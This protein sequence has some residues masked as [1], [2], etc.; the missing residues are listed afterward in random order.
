MKTRKAIIWLSLGHFVNDTYTG[1]I[2]PVMPFIAAKLGITMAAAALVLSISNIFSSMLQPIFGFFADNMLKRLFIFWGLIFTS[3]FIPLMTAA[4]NVYVLIIFIILGSLG[5]S[6]YHPQSTGFVNKFAGAENARE[7]GFFMSMGSAGYA[8]GPLVAAVVTQYFT[9]EK[10]PV[11]SILG[12]LLAG[13]MFLCVPRLSQIYPNPEYK[14]FK[15][16]FAAILSNKTM[17]LLMTVSMMKVLISTSCCTL[18]PFL[19]KNE[20]GYSPLYIGTAL[21]LFVIAGAIGSITSRN[22]EIILGTKN[23]LYF[24]MCATLPMIIT[25]HFTY[26]NHPI[27]SLVMFIITGYTTMLGQPVTM[28][29]G[30]KLLPQ[31]KSTVAGFMNGFAVGVVAVFLSL[32]GLCA[33]KFGITNVLMFLSVIPFAVSRIIKYIPEKLFFSQTH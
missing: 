17:N 26:Q 1:F 15:E 25:F 12:L 24:S 6:F 14:K 22:V 4:S 27:L 11:T 30:Q 10:M 33:E 23:L 31:F 7:I 13:F 2:N 18:L 9:M 20:M 28:V 16:S 5:S 8:M 3:V 32:I 29:M 21:F 19:W